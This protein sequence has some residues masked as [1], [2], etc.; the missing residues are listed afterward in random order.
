MVPRPRLNRLPLGETLHAIAHKRGLRVITMSPNQ[1][2]HALA[3]A[4]EHGWILLEINTDE[5]PVGAY[6]KAT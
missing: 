3:T 5:S 6:Q 4:Y 2:D 1:W